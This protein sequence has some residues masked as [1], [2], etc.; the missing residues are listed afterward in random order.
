MC[1]DSIIPVNTPLA[2]LR[3]LDQRFLQK[4]ITKGLGRNQTS[5]LFP[6]YCYLKVSLSD[7]V[8]NG[9]GKGFTLLIQVPQIPLS[10]H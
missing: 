3:D 2:N 6:P 5:L 9:M 4:K 1:M 8:C 7:C 10:F